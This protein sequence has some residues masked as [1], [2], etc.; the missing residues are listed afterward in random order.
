MPNLA[1]QRLI[2]AAAHALRADPRIESAWLSGSLATGMGDDWSDVDIVAVVAQDALPAAVAA[3][4]ADISAISRAVHSFTV[5]GRIVSAVTPAWE[6]LDLLFVTPAELAARDAGAHRRLFAREGAAAP[7][8]QAPAPRPAT[9]AELETIVREFLRVLGL[10][11]VMVNRRAF[12]T[13]L[14]G[15]MLLRGMLIDLMLAE[16]G[17]ARSERSVKRVTD[18][19]DAEQIVA[20]EALPAVAAEPTSLAAFNRAC[21]GLF[22]PRARALCAKLG[23]T[24]PQAFEDATRAHLKRNLDLDI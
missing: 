20:L 11:D 8:A 22:L 9:A 15:S 3:Y 2:D 17:R 5:Y 21:A 18:M 1:Q 4:A 16:N 23:G 14:D 7:R 13:G 24:W 12:V 6:R 10:G 19:L